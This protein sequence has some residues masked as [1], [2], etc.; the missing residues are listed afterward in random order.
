MKKLFICFLFF[1]LHSS[2]F[3][4]SA[5]TF[6]QGSL[7]TSLSC[8]F[9]VY[10]VQLHD[11][12][13]AANTTQNSTGRTATGNLNLAGEFGVTKW[14]GLGLQCKLDNYIH[15]KDSGGVASANGFEIGAIVNF[16]LIRHLHFDFL[17]GLDLGYSNLTITSNDGYNDQ[18]Y[19]SGT[20]VDLHFTFREYIGRFGFSETLYFPTI[21]YP[22]LTSNNSEF[23][24][25]ILASFKAHGEGLNLGIQYHFLR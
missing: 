3:T 2:F 20:W 13:S 19:G 10:N 15:G 25:Y 6:Q 16:H 21:S 18:V 7:I 22:N 17:T 12:N 8:G 14:L 4:L 24:T 9:D 23:N 5:Q 11:V 1:I